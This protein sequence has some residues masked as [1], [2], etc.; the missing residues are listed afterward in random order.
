MTFAGLIVIALQASVFFTVLSFG[1]A[2]SWDDIRFPLRHPSLLARS[3]VA[4]YIIVPFFAV[5]VTA[6]FALH[7]ATKIAI[8]ALALSP[9]PP[10]LPQ[11]ELKAGGT[12]SYAF[13]LLFI[14]ALLSVVL[15]PVGLILV[16]N[17]F[18]FAPQ[19]SVPAVVQVLLITVIVPFAAGVAVHQYVPIVAARIAKPVSVGAMV[20]LVASGAVVL[21]LLMPSMISLV[22]NGTLV[23]FAAFVAAGLI[24]G[25]LLGGPEANNR[26][27]L[28]LSSAVRHP[29]VALAIASANF[30]QQKLV[31]PAVFLYLL[32]NVVVS[33]PYLVWQRR[34]ATLGE[35]GSPGRTNKPT[36]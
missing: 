7:P 1:L 4:M 24:A 9:I 6:L 13:G 18:G 14:A 35:E 5:A 33:I 19:T 29:A 17:I 15:V 21:A 3:L 36:L 2:S 8:V 27:V 28:A 11:R 25:H 16:A 30:P 12:A 10:L 26:T 22:G 32:V 23:V 31:T 20:V 34:R